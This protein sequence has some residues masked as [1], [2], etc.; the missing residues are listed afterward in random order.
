M[1]KQAVS[2]LTMN[3]GL[4]RIFGYSPIP[5]VTERLAAFPHHVKALG[6]DIICL[7]EVWHVWQ[8]EQLQRDLRE[9]YP[10]SVAFPFH[11]DAT[12]LP[13]GLCIFSR[14]D[15]DEFS[16]REES[17][18]VF[19]GYPA[20]HEYLVSKGAIVSHVYTPVGRI[21]IINTHLVSGGPFF[22]PNGRHMRAMRQGQ[23]HDLVYFAKQQLVDLHVIAGDLNAGPMHSVENYELVLQHGFV[24][25]KELTPAHAVSGDFTFDT[26]NA[27]H[28]KE[29]GVTSGRLDH[30]FLSQVSTQHVRVVEHRVVLSEP[31]VEVSHGRKVPLS[32]HY[33]LLIVCESR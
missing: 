22:A 13:S 12:F 3:L 31:L 26:Q 29:K 4:L 24:D 9:M 17:A 21:A 23:I 7:Q 33:G 30:I 1:S 18:I 25:T 16:L 20:W 11:R 6:A 10:Y 8:Y 32:D 19:E 27:L 28:L 2:I 5:F 15:I 14:H